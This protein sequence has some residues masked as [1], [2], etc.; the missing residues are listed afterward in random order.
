MPQ[1]IGA[2][3]HPFSYMV[4]CP[5]DWLGYWRPSADEDVPRH[6]EVTRARHACKWARGAQNLASRAWTSASCS[7]AKVQLHDGERGQHHPRKWRLGERRH[8]L[9]G[10]RWLPEDRSDPRSPSGVGRDSHNGWISFSG[11][12]RATLRLPRP[13]SSTPSATRRVPLG[14]HRGTLSDSRALCLTPPSWFTVV[15]RS[16][17]RAEPASECAPFASDPRDL[18]RVLRSEEVGIRPSA[19]VP[20]LAPSLGHFTWEDRCHCAIN[21]RTPGP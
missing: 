14:L 2:D 20:R 12:V 9:R 16:G 11:P 18:A 15:F 17:A 6:T 13:H 21:T 3:G 10:H 8:D 19:G 5:A 7:L 4:C 1:K